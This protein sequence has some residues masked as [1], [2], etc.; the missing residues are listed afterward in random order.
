MPYPAAGAALIE[1]LVTF[2]GLSLSAGELH[3]AAEQTKTQIDELISNSEEHRAMVSQL[4][5][6][7][8]STQTQP[9]F[10]SSPLPSGDEIAAELE[11][12]LRGQG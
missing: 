6:Q 2:G 8:D 1:G 7:V 11:R 5:A 10:G 4:E 3:T 9:G 12:F